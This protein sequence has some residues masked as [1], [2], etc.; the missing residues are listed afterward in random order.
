MEF[1]SGWKPHKRI[2]IRIGIQTAEITNIPIDLYLSESSG[3]TNLNLA[4]FFIE[5]ESSSNRKKIAITE[6]DGTTEVKA[7]IVRWDHSARKVWI[8]FK[9]TSISSTSDTIF[10]LYYD[11]T[12]ADNTNIGD[13]TETAAQDVYDNNH[14]SVYNLEQDPSGSAPQMLDSTS[15]NNDGTSNGT[16]TSGDLVDGQIGKGIEFDGVDDDLQLSDNTIWDGATTL[17][18]SS[19]I[20]YDPSASDD[21]LNIITDF[22]HTPSD[23]SLK[24]R[25]QKSR[26]AIL[27]A[28]C[29]GTTEENLFTDNNTILPSTWYHVAVVF[30]G[31]TSISTYINGE[32]S[33]STG[34]TVASLDSE[35]NAIFIG[36]D[37]YIGGVSHYKGIIDQVSISNVARSAEWINAQYIAGKD[38]LVEYCNNNYFTE[39]KK[40]NNRPD[41]I[42]ELDL[43]KSDTF[44]VTVGGA[45]FVTVSGSKLITGSGGSTQTIKKIGM[46]NQF[47]DVIVALDSV[48]ST[49]A[50]IDHKNNVGTMGEITLKIAM[51]PE[52]IV[53]LR[54]EFLNNTPIKIK[55]GFIDRCFPYDEYIDDSEGLIINWSTKGRILT[56]TIADYLGAKVRK[57]IP[58]EVEGTTQ[59]AIFENMNPIDAQIAFITNANYMGV[60][61]DKV[62]VAQFEL[63]RDI[64]YQGW[65][66]H[67]VLTDPTEA[68]KY[69]NQLQIETNS[70]IIFSRTKI[71]FKSFNPLLPGETLKEFDDTT[72]LKVI[73]HDGGY[74]DFFNRYVIYYDYDENGDDIDNYESFKIVENVN[75]QSVD[76]W[77]ETRTK[78]IFCKWI[79]SIW[80]DNPTAITDFGVTVFFTSKNNNNGS[81]RLNYATAGDGMELKWK[82]PGD[83]VYGEAVTVNKSGKYEVKDTTGSKYI[84]VVVDFALASTGF[85]DEIITLSTGQGD[86]IAPALGNKYLNR[87]SNPVGPVTLEIGINNAIIDNELIEPAKFFEL[88]TDQITEKDKETY[89]QEQMIILSVNPLDR[90]GKYRFTALATRL[91][92]KYG[93][94]APSSQTN[95]WDSATDSEKEYAYTADSTQGNTLGAGN[96]PPFLIS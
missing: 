67:R 46:V 66:V 41:T 59:I 77:D 35:D 24:F 47:D 60:D 39:L 25:V 52:I 70:Y 65:K 19:W 78:E 90:V 53:L 88:T 42:V 81:G 57:K 34:I 2:S 44:L 72:H 61:V 1:L 85:T 83:S 9:A 28:V 5:L 26:Q 12:H 27:F 37:A 51:T 71:T 17:T 29:D 80:W 68:N 16:M 6:S 92:N 56:L 54:D 10:Y 18:I 82:A 76:E 79:R 55:K 11:K 4:D 50:K 63:E 40:L 62:N 3:I 15:N 31:G 20:K 89:V 45:F 91:N 95:P 21:D 30:V 23:I 36:R 7:E 75:S 22:K 94:I 69:L 33:K 48:S 84:R 64:W 13:V 49:I 14:L 73:D 86:S 96:D 87:F 38:Q 58:V 74:D 32:L 8:K 43:T 93:V